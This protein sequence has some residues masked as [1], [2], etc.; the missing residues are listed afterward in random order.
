MLNNL[1]NNTFINSQNLIFFIIKNSLIALTSFIVCYIGM[2]LFLNIINKKNICRQPI[3]SS[4]P[5]SHI[6]EKKNTQLWVV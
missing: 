5:E 3:R 4:G 1:F 2:K 6:K